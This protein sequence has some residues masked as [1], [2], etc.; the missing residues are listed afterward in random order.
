MNAPV[1]ESPPTAEEQAKKIEAL[2]AM[3]LDLYAESIAARELSQRQGIGL[4]TGYIV[5]ARGK[6]RAAVSAIRAAHDGDLVEI[7][8]ALKS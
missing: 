7:A 2:T 8:K 4:P 1:L 6:A 3:V 5:E